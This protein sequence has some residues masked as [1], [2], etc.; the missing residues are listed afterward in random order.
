LKSDNAQHW[1]RSVL[2]ADEQRPYGLVAD[3]TLYH[4][5]RT[6]IGACVETNDQLLKWK[7]KHQPKLSV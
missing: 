5:K 3:L 4:N 1:D 2:C 6:N 7:T